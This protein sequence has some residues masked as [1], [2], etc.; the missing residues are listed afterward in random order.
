MRAPENC[1]SR[2]Q[3]R[4]FT[5]IFCL[6]V[7]LVVPRLVWAQ[8]ALDNPPPGSFQSGI[9]VINGFVCEAGMVEIEL[10]NST[11][12][13]AA[14]GTSRGDTAAVCN[15]DGLNG[16]GLL[17]NWNLLGAGEHTIRVLADGTEVASATFTV[18]TL[19]SEFLR[20]VGGQFTVPDF[21]QS[22]MTATVRWE[23]ALQNFV[24]RGDSPA[25]EDS[26]TS[27]ARGV[28]E[29]PRRRS[30]QS[31]IGVVS[32]WVCE[33]DSVEIQF[34]NGALFDA[35]YGTSREDTRPVCGDANN[36]YGLSF[37]WNLLGEGTHTVRALA[38]GVEFASVTFIVS[39]LGVEFLTGVSGAG[40]FAN[41]PRLDRRVRIEWQQSA[42][43]F[44]IVSE[45]EVP[46]G[47]GAQAFQ[48]P[49]VCAE[50]HPR[51][52][53]ELR[54]AV[55]AGYRNMSPTFSS[56]ELA[57]NA[58]VQ[59]LQQLEDTPTFDA[60]PGLENNLRPV[61]TDTPRQ[62]V[63]NR[64]VVNPLQEPIRNANQMRAGFCLGCHN[65]IMTNL[66]DIAAHREVPE[67]DGTLRLRDVDGDGDVEPVIEPRDPNNLSSINSIRPLRDYHFVSGDE[68]EPFG[69]KGRDGCE[70]VMPAQPGS[71]PPPDA[72]PSLGAAGITCDHCHNIS[73]P[74]H[75]RSL[76]GDG[77]AN[78]AHFFELTNIKIG[79]FTNPVPIKDGFHFGSSNQD[80]ID[81][82][83]SNTFCNSCHDVRVPAQNAVAPELNSAAVNPSLPHT[84]GVGHYRLEN[85]G[86]EHV[87]GRYNSTDN[88]FGEAVRCQDCHMSLF[89]YG[90]DSTYTVRDEARDRDLTITSPTPAVFPMNTTASPDATEPGF[91]LPMRPVS[92]HQFTGC[93]IPLLT[94][95]E[96]RA[97]LGDDYPSIDE[98][99][100]DGYGTPLSIR[101]RREDLLKA[102]VRVNLDLT[103]Q[104]AQLGSTFHARVTTTALTGHQFPAGFSQERT[105][106]IQLTVSAKRSGTNE[107]FILYQS[108]YVTDKPHP[109]TG[110]LVPDGILDDEDLEHITAIANPFLHANEV[111][112]LGPDN[113]PEARI[114]EGKT[115]GLVLFRNELLR[116]LDPPA[117]GQ[118]PN[119]L[120]RHPR[121]GTV[122]EYP[123]EEETF[124]AGFA[125][126]VDN[127]RALPALE[128]RTSTYE[129]DLPSAAELA[130]VGVQLDLG[131]G[132]QVHATVHFNHFPPL[133]L[134][135]LARI[136][137]AVVEQNLYDVPTM[138]LFQGLRG[139]Y[140]RNLNLFNEQRI[141]DTLRNVLN[142]DTAELSVPLS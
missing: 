16:F 69:M 44:V 31:G 106:Y 11:I 141:D 77:F 64:N 92:T 139:P 89:P 125:N 67:W 110:E 54:Q 43:N 40:E 12:F 7:G 48:S 127:W 59:Y 128:P 98:P 41:F 91:T 90:G 115:S 57:G 114:F 122:L 53:E 36:G 120:N 23:E 116:V 33:A 101:Q 96:L 135:F 18:T 58:L 142:L 22:G 112:Y 4:L 123:F 140:H 2:H 37:N 47:L 84:T 65:P 108:G 68:C 102:A 83:R 20:G 56:L 52:A 35:A 75:P 9:G 61:Y 95:E 30:F 87:V 71:L 118:E 34:D 109:E 66:G 73:A 17:F 94:D 119:I 82:I 99:G 6:L 107:D 134:R 137:G 105:T 138:A 93:D 132:L 24:I 51:Q 63:N 80:N 104:A 50:C 62:G 117:A 49:I 129:I 1:S 8:A 19:G 38:D 124:S 39:T 85:L 14:Y 74:D 3:R 113:G 78:I 121:T 111:F 15:D 81:Y 86:T 46:P 27:S 29:N 136:T 79:P 28:I 131:Q 5:T 97:Y 21:P 25:G 32:G 103:D 72:V 60:R 88:P 42:Q 76:Q 130:E 10:D 100:V 26:G 133:F 126:A 55:H 45:Q 13:D 70:Q